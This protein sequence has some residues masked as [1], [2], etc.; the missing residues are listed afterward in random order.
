MGERT[1]VALERF[2]AGRAYTPAS[3]RMKCSMSPEIEHLVSTAVAILREEGA[4]EVYLFGTH[5]RG[6]ASAGS[7]LDLAVAGLAPDRY[8]AVI[9]RLMASLRTD[10][11]LHRIEDG[12]PLIKYL[13]QRG[14]L[15]R[16]A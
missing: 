12:S 14:E 15:K 13:R 10:V 11:D 3:C 7:D 6:R 8:Y 16:V 9:G 1:R 5:A 4:S 2:A